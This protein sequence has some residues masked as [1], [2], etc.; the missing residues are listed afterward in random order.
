MFAARVQGPV[1]FTAVAVWAQP[2]PTYSEALR[3]AVAIYR[4]LLLSGPCVVLGDL[5]SSVAWDNRHGR[6][7]HREL[8]RQLREEF[9]LVSAYHVATGEQPGEESRPTH[10]WRWHEE[11]PFHLDY[12]YLPE[13][14]LAGLIS[15][16]V[17][18]YEE[19][20]DASDHR[21]LTVEVVPP[22]ASTRAAV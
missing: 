6:S 1:T 17:G 9:G 11:A 5:N 19:W 8:E 13:Q 18:T 7:D 15:V 16:T 22:P 4:D 21:P 10:F 3:R 12:C 20:A 2:E 14:W